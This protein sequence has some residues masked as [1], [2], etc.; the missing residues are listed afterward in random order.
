MLK[1]KTTLFLSHKSGHVISNPIDIKRGIF[2]GDSLSTLLF[3][4]AL[5]PLTTELNRIDYGYKI[6]KKKY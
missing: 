3:C 6:D 1:W 5:F 2:H 4:I